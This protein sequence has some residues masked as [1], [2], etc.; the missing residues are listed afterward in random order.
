MLK[1]DGTEIADSP[2]TR[3][4]Q[5]K[6][7]LAVLAYLA[8]VCTYGVTCMQLAEYLCV[9]EKSCVHAVDNDL[10]AK[11]GLLP[12]KTTDLI[13]YAWPHAVVIGCAVKWIDKPFFDFGTGH[14]TV[15]LRIEVD[16]Y[17]IL[18]VLLH[19]LF[20]L[21]KGHE[22]IF[23]Q[24]PVQECSEIVD[25]GYL[26]VCKAA[27]LCQRHAHGGGKAFLLVQVDEHRYDITDMAVRALLCQMTDVT[28][29]LTVGQEDFLA[30]AAYSSGQIVSE[31]DLP[32]KRKAVYL[33]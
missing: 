15:C 24:S 30:T 19:F 33:S 9:V 26:K 4:M 27:Y 28:F 23:L 32:D 18:V 6:I 2:L 20:L 29:D 13:T 11:F 31:F 22:Q 7:Y 21:A 10:E 14:D 16:M 3:S 1:K 8:D 25:P 5:Y 17:D 12:Y